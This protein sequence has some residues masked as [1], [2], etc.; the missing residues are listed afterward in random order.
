[1]QEAHSAFIKENYEK[2]IK[3]YSKILSDEKFKDKHEECRLG[4]AKAYLNTKKVDEAIADFK[5]LENTQFSEI[6]KNYSKKLNFSSNFVEKV[7]LTS[8]SSSKEIPVLPNE[9]KSLEVIRDKWIQ[10][11]T[12]IILTLYKKNLDPEKVIV[13][14]QPRCIVIDLE[15][16]DRKIYRRSVA[17]SKSISDKNSSW[18]VTEYK[19]VITLAK[20]KPLLWDTLEIPDEK[21][22]INHSN[23]SLS[24]KK[25]DSLEEALE[26]EEQEE[27]E[28]DNGNPNTALMNMMGKLYREGDDDMRRMIAKTWTEGQEKKN[29]K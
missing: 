1:M 19:V 24:Q 18:I 21:I 12:E 15:L 28:V 7:N 29:L 8:F 10:N 27:K 20:L 23:Q 14:F 9:L 16:K 5:L 11:S 6:V 13:Y 2:S 4:R 25:F 3:Y 26:K 17:L 22:R